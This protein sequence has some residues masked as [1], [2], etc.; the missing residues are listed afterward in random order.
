[1]AT[2]IASHRLG[3]LLCDRPLVVLGLLRFFLD[4]ESASRDLPW[5]VVDHDRFRIK[6]AGHRGFVLDGE[7][8]AVRLGPVPAVRAL[9]I[10][11]YGLSIPRYV[12]IGRRVLVR[13]SQDM[14]ELVEDISSNLLFACTTREAEIHGWLVGGNGQAVSAHLRVATLTLVKGNADFRGLAGGDEF[15][16]DIG[17][18]H[19]KTSIFFHLLVD[20]WITVHELHP[21]YLLVVS[22]VV[23]V[24]G[25]VFV[26]LFFVVVFVV[27]FVFG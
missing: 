21:D 20:G 11:I 8:I 14:S 27:C 15:E 1:M 23:F 18:Y 17:V 7:H 12:G 3:V 22:L 5:D 19:P 26:F 25:C 16:G 24:L 4:I 6:L 13:A 9:V 2:A 10:P